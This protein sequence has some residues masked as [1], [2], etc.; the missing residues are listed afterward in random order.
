MTAPRT[1][2]D[3]NARLLGE[4]ARM[5]PQFQ[6]I[7]HYIRLNPDEVALA[8][9]RVLAGHAKV[10]PT[11]IV[12]FAK[13]MGYA[14]FKEMQQIFK[15]EVFSNSGGANSRLLAL[16]K[17]LNEDEAEGGADSIS[18]MVA[19]QMNSLLSL[20]SLIDSGDVLRLVMLISNARTIWIL[21]EIDSDP[22]AT[23]LFRLLGRVG[24]DA[25]QIRFTEPYALE[26]I[27]HAT[28]DDVVLAWEF[29]YQSPA[30]EAIHSQLEQKGTKIVPITIDG[31]SRRPAMLR[32]VL[33]AAETDFSNSLCASLVLVE[34]VAAQVGQRIDPEHYRPR[35]YGDF[36]PRGW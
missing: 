31:H 8:P 23:H 20:N 10:H 21:S 7:A 5:S 34:V 12:R 30:V 28:A 4:E 29:G 26:R 9:I 14:G 15:F 18:G 17:R 33:P 11:T 27:S 16:Q 25:R 3:F 36:D 24:C 6:Q 1:V 2:P 32:F 19:T 35:D 13:Y 22:A